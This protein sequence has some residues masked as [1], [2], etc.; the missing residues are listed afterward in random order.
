MY[1]NSCTFKHLYIVNA[2]KNP[3]PVP[4]Q[5]AGAANHGHVRWR[6]WRQQQ[7]VPVTSVSCYICCKRWCTAP[8]ANC[9]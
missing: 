6:A 8:D 5:K 1:K 7:Q 4:W 3:P 2:R 9:F